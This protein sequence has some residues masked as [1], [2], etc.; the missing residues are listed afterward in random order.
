MQRED[1]QNK[2]ASGKCPYCNKNIHLK[3]DGFAIGDKA[4]CGGCNKVFYIAGV[5]VEGKDIRLT[6][7]IYKWI[8]E[9]G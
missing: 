6:T 9:G 4:L 7:S 1:S 8:R 3:A 2:T 5:E